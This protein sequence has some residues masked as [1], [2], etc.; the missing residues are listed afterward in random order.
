MML[1]AMNIEMFMYMDI[2]MVSH[3]PPLMNTW[4]EEKSSLLTGYPH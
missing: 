2:V 4:E 1:E 3:L